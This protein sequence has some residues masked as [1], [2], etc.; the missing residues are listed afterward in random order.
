VYIFRIF[1]RLS[2]D[3]DEE[4]LE[5]LET[6]KTVL[7]DSCTFLFYTFYSLLWQVYGSSTFYIGTIDVEEEDVEGEDEE[8]EDTSD[9]DKEKSP[10]LNESWQNSGC[11]HSSNFV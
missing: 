11:L 1:C 4:M 5:M 7:E 9:D 8:K 3:E 10:S 2:D 6:M